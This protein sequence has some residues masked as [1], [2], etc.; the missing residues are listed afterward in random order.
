MSKTLLASAA[1]G[2]EIKARAHSLAPTLVEVRRDLHRHPE[3]AFHEERTAGVVEGALRRLGLKPRRVAGTGVIC[4]IDGGGPCRRAVALRADLDALPVR[5]AKDVPYAST[6]A[7]AAHACGHDGHVAMLLG[8]AEVLAAL[9]HRL[10][11]RVRLI[12]QPGEELIPGGAGLMIN[13]GA[14]E[15]VTAALGM[16]LWTLEPCGRAWCN[17]GPMMAAADE[18]R[19]VIIGRGGHGAAPHDAVDPLLVAAQAVVNLQTVV[20]R[21]VDPLKP[22]VLSICTFHAGSA[23]NIIGDRAE[24]T[25]TVRTLDRGLQDAMPGFIEG[26]LRGTCEAA[27][28]SF[29]LDYRRGYPPVVNDAAAARA[30]RQAC[31]AVLGEGNVLS[32]PPVMGGED[33]ALYQAHV[34][35]AYMFLGAGFAPGSGG[36]SVPHHHPQ[37]DFDERALPLGVEVWAHAALLALE[38]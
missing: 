28:A 2:D 3:L 14:L 22:A 6:V 4:D 36:T 9:R 33:F 29:E 25:G 27:G 26:V 32:L 10:P 7:G 38:L 17:P 15:G 1:A 24:L 11:G 19:I 31:A 18:I 35:G 13:E 5:D 12:F 30:A 34:P 16:H 21:R 20:S 23:Y 8:A 37:F